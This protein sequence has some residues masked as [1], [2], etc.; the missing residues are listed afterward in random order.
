MDV[1]AEGEP[2]PSIRSIPDQ[3][4]TMHEHP[5]AL[6][7]VWPEIIE[8]LAHEHALLAIHLGGSTLRVVAED[9]WVLSVELANHIG[10]EGLRSDTTA[11]LKVEALL[12]SKVKGQPKLTLEFKVK[13]ENRPE[14]TPSG[15]A[16]IHH[17]RQMM[18][19]PI[20][21]TLLDLFEGRII[22]A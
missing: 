11:R 4:P 16:P 8:F 6:E 20:V 9:P 21:K 2:N 1:E 10:L 19:E 7:W 14:T 5:R 12:S 22:T 17:K 13:S 18:D 3:T 15:P